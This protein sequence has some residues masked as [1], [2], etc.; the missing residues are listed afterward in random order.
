MDNGI[1]D[2]LSDTSIDQATAEIGAN[3]DTEDQGTLENYI[4]INIESLTNRKINL[5]KLHLI[6]QIV[7]DVN[8]AQRVPPLSTSEEYSVIL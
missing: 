6:D 8:I 3:F 4:G 5:S 2:S 7:Q 1:F